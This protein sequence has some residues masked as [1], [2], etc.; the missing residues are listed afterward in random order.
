M[1]QIFGEIQMAFTSAND[2]N[3]LQASDAAVVGAGLGD[4]TYVLSPSTLS[5]NQVI[6][7]SDTQGANKLQ[8]IGGLTIAS[9]SVASNAVLLTLSNGAKVT[10]LGADTFSYEVGGN[11]L[12]G[13]AGTVAVSA[14][15]S[16][17]ETAAT[18]TTFNV[19][20][21]NYTY[22][23]AGFGAGDKLVFPTAGLAT[24]V[25]ADLTDGIVDVQYASGGTTT[26]IHL[27]GIPAATDGAIFGVTSFNT[28]FG[29]G[30]L[31]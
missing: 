25:N 8:L 24:I 18:N 14:A 31:A 28:A 16:V 21:G 11:P 17:T 23:I 13:T 2:I 4:D 27:T 7:I 3:I 10:V 9:S 29:A 19:A 1:T 15:G 30:T 5:A 6:Q 12:T 26:V 22:N 20:A